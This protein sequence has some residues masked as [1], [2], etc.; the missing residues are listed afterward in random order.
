MLF[1]K[2]PCWTSDEYKKMNHA[3]NILIGVLVVVIVVEIFVI[4]ACLLNI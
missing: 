2:A 3:T 4:I 1:E